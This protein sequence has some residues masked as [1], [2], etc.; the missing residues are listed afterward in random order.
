MKPKFILI[1]LMLLASCAQSNAQAEKKYDYGEIVLN[2]STDNSIIVYTEQGRQE[3]KI[4][5]N[6]DA[7][8]AILKKVNELSDSGWAVY[9][10]SECSATVSNKLTYYIRKTKAEIAEKSRVTTWSK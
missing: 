7:R 2:A 10:V 1:A 9:N 6:D 8:V 5:K 4:E 3:F